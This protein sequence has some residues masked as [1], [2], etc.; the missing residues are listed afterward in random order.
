MINTNLFFEEEPADKD[1][2]SQVSIHHLSTLI[3]VMTVSMENKFHTGKPTTN[4][5]ILIP[6]NEAHAGT[7]DAYNN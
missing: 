2:Y 1:W 6:F 5:I 7:L 3:L 4:N